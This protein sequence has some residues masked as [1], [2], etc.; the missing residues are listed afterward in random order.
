MRKKSTVVMETVTKPALICLHYQISKVV[1]KLR[2]I[3]KTEASSRRH[4]LKPTSLT[5]IRLVRVA[6]TST[7]IVSKSWKVN[8]ISP[9]YS[10]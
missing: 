3:L 5:I 1:R 9:K 7:I 10:Q 6:P 4:K 2:V 8:H